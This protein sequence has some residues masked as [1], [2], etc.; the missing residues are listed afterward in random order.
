MLAHVAA[1]FRGTIVRL[2]AVGNGANRT[3][4]RRGWS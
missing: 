1:Q 2:A 4:T 3:W